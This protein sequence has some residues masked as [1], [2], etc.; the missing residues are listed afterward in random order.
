M[1]YDAMIME[2]VKSSVSFIINNESFT[3][4]YGYLKIHCKSQIYLKLLLQFT[5][6]FSIFIINYHKTSMMMAI[7][8]IISYF[9]YSCSV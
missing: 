1:N 6:G 5:F 3:L 7:H 4:K 9:F 2:N 8:N